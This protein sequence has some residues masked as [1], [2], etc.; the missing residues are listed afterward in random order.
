MFFVQSILA[1]VGAIPARSLYTA[2]EAFQPKGS[3]S[4]ASCE[5]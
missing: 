2:P 5:T 4:M 1:C 3:C